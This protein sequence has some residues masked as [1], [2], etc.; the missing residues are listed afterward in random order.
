MTNLPIKPRLASAVLRQG[1]V[2]GVTLWPS[3]EHGHA[4]FVDVADLET[5][6]ADLRVIQEMRRAE[7]D[8]E[9]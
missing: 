6:L 5:L 2:I 9:R 4:V 7:Q 3:A 1:R 8:G